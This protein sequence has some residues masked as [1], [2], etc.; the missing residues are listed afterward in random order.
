MVEEEFGKVDEELGKTW[1]ICNDNGTS[2][3]FLSSWKIK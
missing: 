2:L 3:Q 1:R